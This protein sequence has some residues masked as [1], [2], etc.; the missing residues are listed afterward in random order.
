MY[1][2]VVK[3]V[4]T[5]V[6]EAM[7]PEGQEELLKKIMES[8]NENTLEEKKQKDVAGDSLSGD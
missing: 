2:Q 1:K 8:V 5:P 3:E 7:D 6:H 4:Q